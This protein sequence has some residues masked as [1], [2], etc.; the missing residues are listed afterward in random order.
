MDQ[1]SREVILRAADVVCGG[2]FPWFAYPPAQLGFPPSWNLDFVS[3]I[4][5]PDAPAETLQ[6]VRHDGSDVKVPWDLSRLQFLPVMGKAWRLSGNE[7]YRI[8]ACELLSDW[9]GKNPT[10][11]GVNWAI[12]MEAAL[13]SISM[14]LFLSLLAP[15][16]GEHDTAWWREVATSLWQHLLFIEAHNEFSYFCRGNHYLSNLIGLF[17]LSSFLDG[18]G[19]EKR[20]RSYRTLLEQEMMLQ[21]YEDGGGYESSTGY[22]VLNLQMLTAGFLLMKCQSIEPSAEF[23]GRLRGMYRF[24]AALASRCGRVP[25]LG[26]CDDGRIELTVDDLEQMLVPNPDGRHSLKVSGILGTGEA[27]FG[28]DY[29]GTMADAAWYG[30]VSNCAENPQPCG[31]RQRCV[32]FPNSGVAVAREGPLEVVFLAMPNG[33]MGKGT[34]T[35]NDKLSIVVRLKEE[36]V[37]SDAG[38]GCYTRNVKVRNCFRSTSAHNTVQVDGEEQNRFS[39]SPGSTFIISNDASVAPVEKIETSESLVLCASHDGYARLGVRHT[40]KL[41][42]CS[43]PLLTLEDLLTGWGRHDFELRFHLRRQWG[44]K[45]LQPTGREVTCII[46]GA[47]SALQLTCRSHVDLQCYCIRGE[48]SPAYGLVVEA[49]TILVRGSFET[50]V[51]LVSCVSQKA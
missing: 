15:E 41:T 25:H 45:L 34:H 50:A 47:Q 40:R 30:S 32:V 5:W 33:I 21:V 16:P 42:L 23:S 11:T 13:R 3:G 37:F 51:T 12:A 39:K 27:L 10:G 1:R 8:A 43:G 17:C 19:M 20:R 38:T 18:P 9:I 44:V 48:I 35:H 49:H 29:G 36:E 46:E 14:C 2:G 28:E 22:H 26:D 6:V 24:L 7:R 4:S 31:A